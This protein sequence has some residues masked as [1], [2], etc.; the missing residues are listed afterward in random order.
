MN[1]LGVSC[2]YHDSA[3]CVVKDGKL[4]AALEEER[5]TRQKHTDAFPIHA[6]RRCLEISHW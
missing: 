4:V 6:I 2:F 3:A 5:L 1:I